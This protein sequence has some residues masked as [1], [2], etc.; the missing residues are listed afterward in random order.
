[1][2][3]ILFPSFQFISIDF[4]SMDYSYENNFKET[5]IDFD[6]EFITK[7]RK[8]KRKNKLYWN[9]D[10]FETRANLMWRDYSNELN[11]FKYFDPMYDNSSKK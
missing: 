1:M 11:N 3:L 9:Y 6:I 7:K 10:P 4:R 8:K 2:K 5:K